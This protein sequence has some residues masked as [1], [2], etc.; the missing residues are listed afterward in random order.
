MLK[1]SDL[2]DCNSEKAGSNGRFL[3]R[4]RR[5]VFTRDDPGYAGHQ[6]DLVI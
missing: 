2:K 1:I 4:R 5:L 6:K 3:R